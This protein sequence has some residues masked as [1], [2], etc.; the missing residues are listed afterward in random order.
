M[1]GLFN[2]VMRIV[3]TLLGVLMVCMGAV[4][5]LQGLNVAFLESFMAGDPKWALFGA[6]LLL[7]G[8]GQVV[9]SLTRKR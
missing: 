2:A 3:S 7:F 6:I 1:S 8:I 5:I 4:W 9:W